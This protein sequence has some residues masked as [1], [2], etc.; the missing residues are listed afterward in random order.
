MIVIRRSTPTPGGYLVTIERTNARTDGSSVSRDVYVSAERVH[1]KTREEIIEAVQEA[2]G[3]PL[4][5]LRG[6][7]LDAPLTETKAVWEQRA[8][9]VYAVW[10]RWQNTRI[11]AQTR[12]MPA[13]VITALTNREDAAWADYVVILTAWRNA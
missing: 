6:V 1:G 10:Q 9:R 12:A 3:D 4:R 7:D 13:P 2:S 11:E 8:E 5:R